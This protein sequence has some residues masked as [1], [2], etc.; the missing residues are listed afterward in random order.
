M[1]KNYTYAAAYVKS[2]EVNMISQEEFEAVLDYSLEQFENFLREKG[3]DGQSISEMA[4]NERVKVTEICSNLCDND[5]V[6]ETLFL[7]NDFHNIKAV[8]KS[9]ITGL[10]WN[11]LIYEPTSID[12]EELQNAIKSADF[13]GIP[14]RF[15]KVCQKAYEIYKKSG[16]QAMEMYIDKTKISEI[17]S[18]TDGFV[19]GWAELKALCTNLKIYLR[20]SGASKD[21]LE[22]GLIKNNLID[23]HT[24]IE[25][26]KSKEEVLSAMGYKNE[27]DLF[28]KSPTGFEKHCDD[29]VTEYL[30][31]A[32]T[33]FFDFDA[34]LGYFEGKKTEIKN[35]RL[36]A[37]AKKSGMEKEQIK[38][39]LRKTY[40]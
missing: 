33:S 2:L 34:V 24:L 40:V 26:D 21:F 37:S 35:V 17:I 16:G 11:E 27:Y 6:N 4:E 20:T 12:A 13:S 7:E 8:I 5:L 28:L 29:M 25:S 23:V 19:R 31:K 1:N 3:Y 36:I 32:K 10:D 39:R 15:L 38:E 18:K 14:E 22:N 30:W 9:V